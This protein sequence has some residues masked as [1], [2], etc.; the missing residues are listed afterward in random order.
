MKVAALD[1]PTFN[2][3][4]LGQL[5]MEGNSGNNF[6]DPQLPSGHVGADTGDLLLLLAMNDSRGEVWYNDIFLDGHIIA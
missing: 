5:I 3:S 1:D 2:P 6:I 4:S